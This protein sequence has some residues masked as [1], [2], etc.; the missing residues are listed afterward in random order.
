ML[1]SINNYSIWGNR[2]G[3]RGIRINIFL[4]VIVKASMMLESLSKLAQTE[5]RKLSVDTHNL[6]TW[7]YHEN[8]R[9]GEYDDTLIR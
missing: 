2:L 6:W 8:N 4:S 9:P 3:N 5:V 1:R 7:N